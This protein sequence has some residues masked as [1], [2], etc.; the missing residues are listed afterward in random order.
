VAKSLLKVSDYIEPFLIKMIVAAHQPNYLP[1]LAFFNKMAKADLFVIITN[2]QFEKQ[3]G[4]Q[5]RH[6]I[7]GPNG[8]IWLTVPVLGSQNQLIKEVKINQ[9]LPWQRKHTRTLGTVYSKTKEKKALEEI[10]KLY[11]KDWKRLVDLN[12]SLILLLKKILDIKTPVVVDE[13]VSG[14]KHTLIINVCK[15]HGAD[16]Y[17]S[18]VG[19]KLYLDEERLEELKKNNIEHRIVEKNLTALYPYSTVHYLLAEGKDWVLN[20]I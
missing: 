12:V 10:I 14:V 11:Q 20:A 6:K 13:D 18:G 7:P 2:L 3:E 1:N 17:L 16:I 19:A 8:D 5:Q 15:S 4:W 9:K